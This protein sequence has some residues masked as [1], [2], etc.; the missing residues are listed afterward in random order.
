VSSAHEAPRTRNQKPAVP[1][2]ADAFGAA[3][4]QALTPPEPDGR[5]R[6]AAL[7]TAESLLIAARTELQRNGDQGA[8]GAVAPVADDG[9]S[10]ISV[11]VND[12]TELIMHLRT[13][14]EVT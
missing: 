14:G 10:Q 9:A 11:L 6:T 7:Q 1:V 8:D 5:S 13:A 2:A 3:R 4:S 12:L